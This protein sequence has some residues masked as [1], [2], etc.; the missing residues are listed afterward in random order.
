MIFREGSGH[1]SKGAGLKKSS[2]GRQHR[3]SRF[4]SWLCKYYSYFKQMNVFQ[5]C[6]IMSVK[7]N[8]CIVL[9]KRCDATAVPK[10]QID[11]DSEEED[12]GLY[13]F[14]DRILK[15]V[16]LREQERKRIQELQENSKINKIK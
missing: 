15:E 11:F 7:C 4:K 13:E 1:D 16:E 3:V 9:L 14:L 2:Y 12:E 5:I 8:E 6:I 10:V